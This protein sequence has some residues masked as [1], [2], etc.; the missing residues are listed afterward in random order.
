MSVVSGVTLQT[1]LED[2][3]ERDGGPD[4]VPLI[5]EINAW[6]KEKGCA[7]LVSVEAAYGGSKHP[8]VR[9][10]G[11]GFNYFPKD[12]FVK[13]VMGIEWQQPESV[14][15]LINPEEG[16]TRVFRPASS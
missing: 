5:E 7:P 13:F 14:V 3:I 16:A 10:Y 2:Y 15:L 9:V 4:L 8:Q 11:C 6:L 12:E 1:G